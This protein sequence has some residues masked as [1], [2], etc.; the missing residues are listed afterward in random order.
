MNNKCKFENCAYTHTKDDNKVKIEQFETKCSALETEVKYLK[1]EQEKIN[2]RIDMM[3]RGI[4]KLKGEVERLTSL[5]NSMN[6]TKE[7]MRNE[8]K[9]FDKSKSSDI[10]D[11]KKKTKRNKQ[12]KEKMKSEEQ[13]RKAKNTDVSKCNI[14]DEVCENET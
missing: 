5:C 12:S 4:M 11:E 2:P 10:V 8:N 13:L 14:C 9:I 1:V 3:G 6:S 7:I